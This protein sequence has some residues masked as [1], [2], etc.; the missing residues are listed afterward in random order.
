M[1]VVLVVEV[2]DVADC[3][4]DGVRVGGMGRGAKGGIRASGGAWD[5]I[6]LSSG[7]VDVGVGFSGRGRKRPLGVAKDVL[8]IEGA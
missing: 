1:L 3:D 2:A 6:S 4:S 8:S 5:L 7:G